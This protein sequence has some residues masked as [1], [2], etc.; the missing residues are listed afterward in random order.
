M[1]TIGIKNMPTRVFLDTNILLDE[2]FSDR[3]SS[4]ATSEF[5]GTYLTKDTKFIIN[6][7]TLNTLFYIGSKTDKALTYAFIKEIL[8]NERFYEIYSPTKAD[9]MEICAIYES[10][11]GSD[12]EDLEQYVCAKNSESDFIVTNDKNFPKIEMILKR[13]NKDIGDYYPK[14]V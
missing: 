4:K 13:T 3:P 2:L 11:L 9:F 10:G 12:L 7:L 8:F 5:I 1:T 14:I 6:T